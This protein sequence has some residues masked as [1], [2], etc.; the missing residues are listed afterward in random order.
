MTGEEGDG[1]SYYP[2]VNE[3]GTIITFES[4]ASNLSTGTP[5]SNGS[6]RIHLWHRNVN[7]PDT[8]RVITNGNGNS[9]TPS[10]SND[11]R[12]ITYASDA[13][14]LLQNTSDDS[15]NHRD[16][17]VFDADTNQTE[18]VNQTYMDDQPLDGP[19]DQPVISGDG[20]YIAFRSEATNML[21]QGGI[22]QIVVERGGAGYFGNPTI[23]ISDLDGTGEG[24]SISFK[25]N[26]INQYGQ[27]RPDG[28]DLILA[29]RNYRNP[30]IRII[31]DPNFP[32]T[33]TA[34]LSAYLVNSD[35]EVY[36][37]QNP[38]V[39][40]G[41]LENWARVSESVDGVGGN[42]PS[43]EPAINFDG[44]VVVYSTQASNFLKTI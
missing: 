22:A 16:I 32:P 24:A 21:F 20:N 4:R 31:P 7:S 19:S 5:F 2:D 1:A 12:Y 41:V 23:E 42:M 35:G 27:V 29:G 9:H 6:R 34:I 3:D 25:E 44:S 40:N 14:N 33:Q 37:V 30:Q 11:G 38:L 15:N 18:R 10:I 8:V 39:A 36:R 17:F 13:N 28:I 26:G 43:R